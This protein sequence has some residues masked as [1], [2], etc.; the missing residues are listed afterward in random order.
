M[1]DKD[2]MKKIWENADP[3]V[4]KIIE[5]I[6]EKE[7]EKLHMEKPLG[8]KDDILDIFKKEIIE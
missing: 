2:E 7:K 3:Q 1:V 8:I 5:R 4:R 6:L